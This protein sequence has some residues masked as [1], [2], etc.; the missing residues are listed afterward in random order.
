[1]TSGSELM[2]SA[3]SPS[4]LSTRLLSSHCSAVQAIT[5]THTHTYKQTSET[6]DTQLSLILSV[7]AH[8]SLACLLICDPPSP[9]PHLSILVFPPSVDLLS[10]ILFPRSLSLSL[11]LHSSLHPAFSRPTCCSAAWQSDSA[12][13][14]SSPE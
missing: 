12:L 7:R 5:H 1:M 10:S 3:M 8:Q 6:V 4:S 14:C 9:S 2:V 11:S 13:V